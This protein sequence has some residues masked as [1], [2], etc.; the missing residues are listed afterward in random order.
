[1]MYDQCDTKRGEMSSS[2]LTSI[3]T[4]P[5][6]DTSQQYANATKEEPTDDTKPETLISAVIS[7]VYEIYFS[8]FNSI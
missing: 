6:S 3:Q 2:E 7:R 8:Q 5:L 4:E 1:M